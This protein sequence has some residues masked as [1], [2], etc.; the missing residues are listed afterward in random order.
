MRSMRRIIWTLAILPLL[1]GACVVPGAIPLADTE[2]SKVTEYNS[3]TEYNAERDAE[4]E[5][6]LAC[7]A[8]NYPAESYFTNALLPD[9]NAPWEPMEC[10]SM[11]QVRVGMSWILNDGGAP[12]YNAVELGFFNDVCLEAELVRGGSGLGSLQ[13]LI[14]GNVE[15]AVNAGGGQVPALALS[16]GGEDVIAVGSLIK[17]SPYIWLGLDH[18][19]PKDQRSAKKLTP[20]DLIG[21]T[22]GLHEGEDHFFD[23]ISA[24]YG[25]SSDQVELVPTGYTPD[26]VL[27]GEMDYAG[28]WLIN[29]PRL[30]EEQG[31]M[32]WV[33]FQFSE[34]GWDAYAGVLVVR[35]PTLEENP[36]LVRRYLAAV[37]RGLKYV[38][39]NPE[40]SARIAVMY[41]V[42]AETTEEM[43][44]R[45]FQLQEALIL[46]PDGLPLG[47]MS[48]ARWNMQVA[49]MI[50]FDLL[51]LPKCE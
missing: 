40:D 5:R 37:I 50:R 8:E 12:W 10:E 42:D 45:R 7:V 13:T 17:H 15:F 31:Y 26:P 25:I 4:F 32:N 35:R 22:I 19:T 11:D 9:L 23:F 21:K 27:A 16:P 36:D 46:D 20:Q 43:A 1:L 47:H 49:S 34:W 51:E 48:A 18:D 24:K 30:M 14:D 29:E 2:G 28:A 38:Q 33:A 41:A 6:I 44:Q 39:E 3:V